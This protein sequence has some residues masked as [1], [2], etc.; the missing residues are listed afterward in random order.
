MRP[1]VRSWR[2]AEGDLEL[3]AGSSKIGSGLRSLVDMRACMMDGGAGGIASSVFGHLS[4]G[5]FV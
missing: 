3:A 5:I 4:W 2:V 1:D